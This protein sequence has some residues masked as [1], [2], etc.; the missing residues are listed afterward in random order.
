V[1]RKCILQCSRLFYFFSGKKQGEVKSNQD[2]KKGH[3]TKGYQN[4]HHKDETSKSTTFFDESNDE[5][6]HFDYQGQQG[7]YGDEGGSSFKGA[8]Q[9]GSFAADAKGKQGHYDSGYA[10]DNQHGSKGSQSNQEYYGDNADYGQKKA[11]D[12]YGKKAALGQQQQYGG[13]HGQQF[14]GF[15]KGGDFG[16]YGGGHLGYLGPLGY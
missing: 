8:L 12:D 1:E 4:F 3:S 16:T 6:N 2:H 11:F 7:S 15:K 10:T 14:G 9:D 13:Y 5:G